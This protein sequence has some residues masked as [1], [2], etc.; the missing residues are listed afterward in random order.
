MISL[1]NI[2]QNI[3]GIQEKDD[4]I[5]IKNKTLFESNIVFK[6]GLSVDC[7]QGQIK[8]SQ[9]GSYDAD[10]ISSG[11]INH[12]L[13]KN[14]NASVVAKGVFEKDRIGIE[15]FK[16]DAAQI[17][18]VNELTINSKQLTGIINPACLPRITVDANDIVTGTI[19]P[20]RLPLSLW[21]SEDNKLH[22][23]LINN[24]NG[25]SITNGM[26]KTQFLEKDVFDASKLTGTIHPSIL[27][28]WGIN[29][30]S[31]TDGIIDS[32]RIQKL[33]ASIVTGVLNDKTIPNINFN[34]IKG[35]L[36]SD[37]IHYIPVEKIKGS[38]SVSQLPNISVLPNLKINASQI[39]SGYLNSSVQFKVKPSQIENEHEKINQKIIPGL[40]CNHI[41]SGTFQKERIPRLDAEYITSG[42]LTTNVLS[43]IYQMLPI[44]DINGKISN[45]SKTVTMIQS[46]EAI[47]YNTFDHFKT[48]NKVL[49]QTIDS[50][51]S[52]IQ[53]QQVEHEQ[54]HSSNL[55]YIDSYLRESFENYI[56]V[57]ESNIHNFLDQYIHNHQKKK[58]E[59]K[60]QQEEQQKQ[61]LK[62]VSS[63][64][65]TSCQSYDSTEINKDHGLIVYNENN[66]WKISDIEK[67]VRAIGIIGLSADDV[68]TSGFANVRVCEKHDEIDEIKRGD[69]ITSSAL[70]GF[71][72]K[73]KSQ[74][75]ANYTI[76][77]I[78]ELN[79]N[80]VA[81]YSL[82]HV[83]NTTNVISKQVFDQMSYDIEFSGKL[84]KSFTAKIKMYH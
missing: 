13:I 1:A 4:T 19:S 10:I 27:P 59:K 22:P 40:S 68:I 35:T 33:D 38:L 15:R 54:I 43:N 29:A 18:G 3:K 47:M 2:K 32:N 60:K 45:L 28:S 80:N 84:Y 30:S 77:K 70:N 31:I 48:K 49:H 57:C 72:E 51:Q 53:Q 67:D 64:T 55:T 63:E 5:I 12:S 26:I 14:L 62:Y 56:K 41:I 61:K 83:E 24:I 36:S 44:N 9:L 37:Q 8:R 73:Q 34:K 58:E 74:W 76:G 78:I 23:N 42:Q 17:Y 52:D 65:Q 20:Q 11:V 16:I 81:Y 82:D 6:H 7:L 75:I 46:N 21:F 79:Q 50:M 69:L 25:N 71:G 39:D 66:T